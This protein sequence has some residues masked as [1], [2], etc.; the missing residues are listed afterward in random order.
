MT[1]DQQKLAAATYAV[2][3]VTDG[4]LVGLGSGSTAA[5]MIQALAERV[6]DGL[7]ITGVPT[8]RP[9]AALAKDLGIPLTELDGRRLDLTIDGADEVD[10]ERN[11]IKGGG[12]ALLDEKLVALASE[13]YVIIVDSGKLVDRLGQRNAVPIETVRFGWQ[14]TRD[15][16]AAGGFECRLRGG[17]HPFVS[18]DGNYILDC[19]SWGERRLADPDVGVS[20]KSMSGVIE[21]GLFI[22]FNPEIVVGKANGVVDSLKD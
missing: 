5:L 4:M 18:S 14:T 9:S 7:R 11:L 2:R 20:I 19:F 10:P 12:G 17:D 8:S 3:L 16:L 13:R 15:R 22:G 1:Q 21:H 6:R